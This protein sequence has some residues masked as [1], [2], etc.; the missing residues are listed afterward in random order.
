MLMALCRRY[1]TASAGGDGERAG[2][3]AGVEVA[4]QAGDGDGVGAIR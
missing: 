1:P 4:L 2:Q 3:R